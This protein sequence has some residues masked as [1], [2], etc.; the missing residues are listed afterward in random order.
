MEK[1]DPVEFLMRLRSGEAVRC[2]QC[3]KGDVT[4]EHEP[5]TCHYFSCDVC[6]FEMIID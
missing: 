4:A 6:E 5:K 1:I 2:P 3:G